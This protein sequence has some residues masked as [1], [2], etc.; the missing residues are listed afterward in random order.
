[1][2]EPDTEGSIYNGA[3][4]ND[5]ERTESAFASPLMKKAKVVEKVPKAPKPKVRAAVKAAQDGVLD[6]GKGKAQGRKSAP[7]VVVDDEDGVLDLDPTPVK[8]K[9]IVVPATEWDIDHNDRWSMPT[10]GDDNGPDVE[11]RYRGE[12]LKGRKEVKGKH[13]LEDNRVNTMSD[14]NRKNGSDQKVSD[15][16]RVVSDAKWV[17]SESKKSVPSH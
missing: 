15:T 1:M 12:E 8:G 17:P 9:K 7:V 13:K 14:C 11:V 4:N 3:D 2:R 16:T 5:D 10:R 6:K